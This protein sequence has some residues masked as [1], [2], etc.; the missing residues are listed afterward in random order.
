MKIKKEED[1]IKIR[2]YLGILNMLK[3]RD[4]CY[5]RLFET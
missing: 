3:K 4:R 1:L 2:A 5:I